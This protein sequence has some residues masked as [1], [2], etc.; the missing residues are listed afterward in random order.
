MTKKSLLV[1]AVVAVLTGLVV[2]VLNRP[3][4]VPAG[5]GK[6]APG[7]RL[8]GDIDLAAVAGLTVQSGEAT[9]TL[10]RGADKKWTVAEREGVTADASRLSEVLSQLAEIKIAQVQQAGPSQ[11]PRLQLAD[12]A[13]TGDNA[14]KNEEKGTL[15]KLLDEKDAPIAQI[16]LGKSPQSSGPNPMSMFG[17]GTGRFV[18]T[19]GNETQVALISEGLAQLT[20]A[21]ADW[22]SKTFLQPGALKRIAVA[23]PE[24]FQPWEVSRDKAE[25]QFVLKDPPAGKQLSQTAAGSWSSLLS[26][27]QPTDILTKAE[28]EKLDK[29]ETRTVTLENF[30]GCVFMLT[31]TPLPKDAPKP[32]EDAAA[33]SGQSFYAVQAAVAG[34]FTP[35]APPPPPVKPVAPAADANDEAKKKFEEEQKAYDEAIKGH[36]QA[37][38]AHEQSVAAARKAWD[39]KLAK[40]QALGAHVFKFS[41]Y[42]FD[43][44]WKTRDEVVENIPPP[45]AP[46]VPEPPAVLTPEGAPV[47]PPPAPQP[48]AGAKKPAPITVTTPPIAVPPAKGDKPAPAAVTTPPV[49]VPPAGAPAQ[50]DPKTPQPAPAPAPAEKKPA[51]ISVTTPPIAVPPAEPAAEAAKPG[52]P[53]ADKPAPKPD[54]GKKE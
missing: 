53:P 44:V 12:P 32:G 22:I 49:A 26:Y 50:G 18:R 11:Y 42:T 15:V 17:G 30:D 36:E 43:S 13:A 46:A 41:S 10:K 31:I 37:V 16:V 5:T 48:A 6:A 25:G 35:A 54:A 38:K 7:A 45:P 39:E 2:L 4:A 51:P 1:L 27:A 40:D 28:V 23:G 47:P 33:A 34:T 21:P 20:A 3:S 14:P 19:V 24:G 8:L 29:K 52:Q 9:V